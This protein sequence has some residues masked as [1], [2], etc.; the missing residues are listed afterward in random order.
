MA[1]LLQGKV[2]LVTGGGSGIGRAT[3]IRLAREGA[4]VMIADYVP[5]GAEQTV[6]MIK[7]AGGEASCTAADV[8][9]TSEVEA[10]IKKT[11]DTYGRLDCAYNN[12]GIEGAM[13]DT[14]ACTEENF[15]RV[16]AIDL[17]AVW[18]CM[19]YEIPQMLKQGGGCDRQHRLHRGTGRLQRNTRLRCR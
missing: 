17:K 11:L 13:G 8:A 7:E 14:V 18:L 4:K 16:V 12:A 3:S 15:D 1:G 10:M 9:V 6:K 19:K 2:A 5:A